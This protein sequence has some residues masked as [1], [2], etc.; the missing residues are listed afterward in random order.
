MKRREKEGKEVKKRR[1]RREGKERGREKEGRGKKE[2]LEGREKNGKEWKERG[3]KRVLSVLVCPDGSPRAFSV[4]LEG[5]VRRE[6]RARKRAARSGAKREAG[7]DTEIYTRVALAP[8]EC[9][10]PP[11]VLVEIHL[12]NI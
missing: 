1:R 8:R 6:K 4:L 11:L 7:T 12:K 5:T 2:G 9:L 10:G 3:L